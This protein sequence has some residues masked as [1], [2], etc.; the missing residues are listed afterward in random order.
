MGSSLETAS[1]PPSN[2]I[3]PPPLCHLPSSQLHHGSGWIQQEGPDLLRYILLR[4]L[5][6]PIAMVAVA[7]NYTEGDCE[8]GAINYLFVA[9]VLSLVANLFGLVSA[10]LNWC[11]D[12]DNEIGLCECLMKCCLGNIKFLIMIAEIVIVIW[13]SVVV[14][15][16]YASWTY[17]AKDKGN[18]KDDMQFCEYTPMQFAFVLLILKWVMFPIYICCPLLCAAL[19]G[20]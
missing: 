3:F 19:C 14:F 16:N 20:S 7:N 2:S 17:D 9:G 13:G 11:M 1:P 15:G 6:S 4:G 12:R 18:D 10:F 8:F 5:H